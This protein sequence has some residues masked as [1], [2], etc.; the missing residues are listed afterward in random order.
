[1]LGI[2]VGGYIFMASINNYLDKVEHE[3]AE[4]ERLAAAAANEEG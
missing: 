3:A 1:M 4:E 2:S